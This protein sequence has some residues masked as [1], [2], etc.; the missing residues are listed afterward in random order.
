MIFSDAVFLFGFF[1]L[2]W[3]IVRLSH[4]LGNRLLTAATLIVISFAFYMQWNPQDFIVVFTSVTINFLIANLPGVPARMKLW[5]CV[6]INVGYLF[7]LKFI[8]A[9]G[10]IS[11]AGAGAGNLFGTLG[12]PLGISFITFQQIGFVVDQVE[13]RDRE[14]N[15]IRYLFFVLFF[16]HLIAGPL[17]PHRMLCAQ[18]DRK[19]FLCPSLTFIK[20]GFAYLAIGLAKKL[21]I[22]EPLTSLNN[23]LFRASADLSMVEAWYNAFLYSFRIYFD[24]S[25]YSDLA[26]GVA[27]IFG[28]QFPRNFISPY[29]SRNIFEFWRCWHVSLYKFFRQYLYLRLVTFQF[30]RSHGAMA[31]MVVMVL[32]AFWH[33]VGWGYVLWG[34]GHG[35]AMIVSRQLAKKSGRSRGRAAPWAVAGT[36][37]LVT[38]LWVPFALNNVERIGLYFGRMLSLSGGV[39][40]LG[41]GR[42]LAFLL[43]ALITF[44]L[45]NSHQIAFGGRNRRWLWPLALGLLALSVP[46]AIGRNAP[47][48]PFI[49][50]QF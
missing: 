40:H 4:L 24:F 42:W 5:A 16:P 20:V 11:T 27:Y 36:F 28:I 43:P 26:T 3:V 50:F 23:E 46:L 6:S 31:I 18:I 30:F 14:P 48:P 21:L 49:Y 15:F 34:V 10:L 17:V 1:P 19:P 13:G 41:G 2:A 9:T 33:G 45:P 47:P 12:L 25:A 32:S 38:V 35:A 7:F 29:K 22:A 39:D 8:V 37:I 44:A